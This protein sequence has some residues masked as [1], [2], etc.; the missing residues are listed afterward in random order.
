MFKAVG[1]LIFCLVICIG[2]LLLHPSQTQ[3]NPKQHG[4]RLHSRISPLL[5]A[6]LDFVSLTGDS[7][8]HNIASG[9]SSENTMET[10]LF[11]CYT[12][13]LEYP[14]KEIR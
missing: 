10:G 5:K 6:T 9:F 13:P 12:N 2:C 3:G 7:A 1:K 8:G 11:N 4:T 14:P